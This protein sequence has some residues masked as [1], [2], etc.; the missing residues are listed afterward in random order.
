MILIQYN[1]TLYCFSSSRETETVY[2]RQHNADC[3]DGRRIHVWWWHVRSLLPYLQI[4]VSTTCICRMRNK[5]SC[6]FS[7]LQLIVMYFAASRKFYK[8]IHRKFRTCTYKGR[9]LRKALNLW[10]DF[11]IHVQ[12]LAMLI[13]YVEC[14]DS[15]LFNYQIILILIILYYII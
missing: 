11:E 8:K 13:A 10:P 7:R 5:S 9:T 12:L 2:S 14:K 6:P 4:W 15:K 3:M 1:Y